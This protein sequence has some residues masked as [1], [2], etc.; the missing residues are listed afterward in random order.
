MGSDLK[1]KIWQ[2]KTERK[3]E[4]PSNRKKTF[5]SRQNW[6]IRSGEENV[7]LYFIRSEQFDYALVVSE[8][9][10]AVVRAAE[11]DSL[12]STASIAAAARG[13]TERTVI[14]L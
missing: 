10:I 4:S 2:K 11:S 5:S 3:S 14:S 12:S 9:S 13:A 6:K 1:K 7:F 8:C